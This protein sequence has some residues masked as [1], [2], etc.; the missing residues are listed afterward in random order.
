MNVVSSVP[1]RYQPSRLIS[2]SIHLFPAATPGAPLIHV[3]KGNG[4]LDRLVPLLT[5][6]QQASFAFSH[7]WDNGTGNCLRA[8]APFFRAASGVYVLTDLDAY[9]LGSFVTLE[10]A[11]KRMS[12][13]CTLMGISDEWLDAVQGYNKEFL[14]FAGMS[15]SPAEARR[16]K[17]LDRERPGLLRAFGPKCEALV[18]GNKVLNLEAFFHE[19]WIEGVRRLLRSKLK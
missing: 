17:Q 10:K 7:A 15:I 12:K 11:L 2:S 5:R 4:I 6:R 8:A 3:C 13:S 16:I 1:R 19:P 18:S 14:S 9:G